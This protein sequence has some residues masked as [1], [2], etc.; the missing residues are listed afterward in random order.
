MSKQ[1]MTFW[2]F[3]D[4]ILDRMP[5]WPE[6]RQAVT[7]GIFF[8]AVLL[9]GMAAEDKALWEVE[10]FKVILQAIVIGAI[11]NLVVSFHYAANKSEQDA[12]HQR[13]EIQV[14]SLDIASAAQE[15]SALALKTATGVEGEESKP[16]LTVEEGESVTIAGA[17]HTEEPKS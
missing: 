11:I 14:K 9:L 12:S 1:P 17:D 2:N 6:E 8:L 7:F 13:R 4:S 10:I 15:A 3:C 5:G 16:D